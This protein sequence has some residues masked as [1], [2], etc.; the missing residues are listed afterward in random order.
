MSF[1]STFSY[2]INNLNVE[3]NL[4]PFTMGQSYQTLKYKG[5]YNI[6]LVRFTLTMDSYSAV[7]YIPFYQSNIIGIWFPFHCCSHQYQ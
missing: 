4:V 1:I 3:M 6:A 2:Q 7:I 5:R